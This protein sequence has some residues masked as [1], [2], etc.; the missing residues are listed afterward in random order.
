[1]DHFQ[2]IQSQFDYDGH[3][4]SC[5]QNCQAFY[6]GKYFSVEF[7]IYPWYNV[8]DIVEKGA[9][10]MR[11]HNKLTGAIAGKRDLYIWREF[12]VVRIIFI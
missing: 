12:C 11:K 10:P 1:L 9:C 8:P 5:L 3:Y 7:H 2:I 6:S 4:I